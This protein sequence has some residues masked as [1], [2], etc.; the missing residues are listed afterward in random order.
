[1][2]NI[3]EYRGYYIDHNP[4]GG[5]FDWEWT[6]IDFSLDD[7]ASEHVGASFTEA[8]AKSAIDFDILQNEQ[9]IIERI[10]T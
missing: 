2:T 5:A 10:W 9:Q 3:Q 6:R 4:K 8:A 1:M 7:D